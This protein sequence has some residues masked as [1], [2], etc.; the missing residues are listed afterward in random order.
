MG[1]RWVVTHFSLG[2]EGSFGAAGGESVVMRHT[3]CTRDLKG[4]Q[5]AD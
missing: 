5:T 1:A 3:T 4:S 2:F